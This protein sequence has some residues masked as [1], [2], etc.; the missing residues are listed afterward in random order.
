MKL[1]I[2]RYTET[3]RV[4]GLPGEPE[5]PSPKGQQQLDRLAVVCKEEHAQ[6]VIHS[7][8]PR[9]TIAGD[10]LAQSLQV[11]AIPL[12]GLKERDF[13]DWSTWDWPRI[14]LQISKLT[15]EDRY[16][17]APPH[18]ESWQQMDVR[19][20]ATL[21]AIAALKY[22][23]VAVMTHA[24]CIRVLMVLLGRESKESV[25]RFIPSLGTPYV[26]DYDPAAE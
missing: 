25:T 18:G 8:S 12:N 23:S 19:L 13:G 9:T 14:S 15:A 7:P 11:P 10:T 6:A 1:I 4:A 5:A 2:T 26:V 21:Q 22:D 17:F 3:N 24:S 16:A 20:D